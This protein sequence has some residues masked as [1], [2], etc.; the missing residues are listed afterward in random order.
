MLT[1]KFL[2]P[3]VY[4]IARLCTGNYATTSHI[5][6]SIKHDNPDKLN[7]TNRDYNYILV[8]VQGFQFWEFAFYYLD[9]IERN[10]WNPTGFWIHSPKYD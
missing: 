5:Y 4:I 1:L 9:T 10:L 6:S 8:S 2:T 7:I 3:N